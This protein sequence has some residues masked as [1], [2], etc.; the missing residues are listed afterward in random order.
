MR[1]YFKDI[2]RNT[3]AVLGGTSVD[4]RSITNSYSFS[5][6]ISSIDIQW[7]R[8]DN[9]TYNSPTDFNNIPE[10]IKTVVWTDRSPL[11]YFGYNTTIW[12]LNEYERDSNLYDLRKPI[13]NKRNIHMLL[14]PPDGCGEVYNFHKLFPDFHNKFDLV[15]THNRELCSLVD[16]CKWYPWGTSLL[17][18][19]DDFKIYEKSK[20]VTYNYSY[21]SWWSGHRFRIKIGDQLKQN[22]SFKFVDITGPIQ[23]KQYLSKLETLKDYFFA[24][25]IENQKVDDFFTD[26][27]IDSFL[28]GTIPIYHGTNNICNYFNK[29]GI[30]QFDTYDELL[31]ILS[32]ITPEMY[33]KKM[34]AVIENFR[35]AHDY[36]S[37]DDWIYKTYGNNVFI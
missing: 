30:I 11:F 19:K 32:N 1:V 22:N 7:W 31:E 18:S 9:E 10:D 6:R 5:P 23:E 29:D 2:E 8:P 28:T 15:L 14:E 27:I 4:G 36:I 25:Q 17:D 35:R 26:K 3:G 12:T 13:P 20:L 37:P 33:Y 16:N 21:K 24:V 34:D